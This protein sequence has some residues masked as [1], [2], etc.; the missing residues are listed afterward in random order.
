[1]TH[2][3]NRFLSSLL[4]KR[5]KIS[6]VV[7]VQGARQTGKSF[8][9]R[10]LLAPLLP[11]MVYKTLDKKAERE[12]AHENPDTFLA[13]FEDKSP[14]VIDEAQKSPN[15]FDAIKAT[16]DE[17][18]RPG[19]FI[20]LGSTEFS[21][22]FKIR[23]SL[24]GRM[25]RVRLFPLTLA[26]S[27]KAPTFQDWDFN[28]LQK[29]QPNTHRSEVL[30]YLERGG[31]PGIFAIRENE[32][33]RQ[34]LNDWLEITVQRDLLQIPK[35]KLSPDLALSILEK[36]AILPEP[37][38]GE[39]A[40]SIRVDARK[41]KTHM[42]ALQSLFVISSVS[43]F[44]GSSGKELWFLLDPAF[45]HILGGDFKRK[46]QTWLL[47]EIQVRNSLRV[48]PR[49]IHFY[50]TPKGRILDFILT[51]GKKMT[52]IQIFDVESLYD[53]DLNLLRSFG[54]KN[55]NSTLLALSGSEQ[56]HLKENLF[57]RPW[58]FLG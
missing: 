16:V 25:S 38:I 28:Q 57:V 52:A 34:L 26:E 9:V 20:L 2:T 37:S 4:I 24:T 10:E 13:Q 15:L 46:L 14:V 53:R 22:L 36:M 30:K 54:K 7:A 33:R 19:R 41:I 17:N 48:E 56:N 21:L 11:H 45:V 32:V 3:R 47:N 6:P 35:L 40:R 27:R 12:Y 8:L 44:P 5:L 43:P 1:L 39:I 58:E 42:E 49:K 50:R 18:R 55:P 29:M 31:M 23:E 51:E